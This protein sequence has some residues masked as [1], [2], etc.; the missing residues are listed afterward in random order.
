LGLPLIAPFKKNFKKGGEKI[1]KGGKKFGGKK[2][3]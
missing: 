3:I 1:K 2:K